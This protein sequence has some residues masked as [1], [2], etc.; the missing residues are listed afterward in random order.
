LAEFIAA[1]YEVLRRP[2]PKRGTFVFAKG[3]YIN[4]M[5]VG[6]SIAVFF[7]WCCVVF[8]NEVQNTNA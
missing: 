4:T 7:Y 6:A 3:C 5:A 2:W 8:A 1:K